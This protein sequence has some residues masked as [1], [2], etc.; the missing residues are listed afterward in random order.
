MDKRVYWIWLSH[1]FGAGSEKPYSIHKRFEGGVEEFHDGKSALWNSLR[2]ISEKEARLLHTFTLNQ[3]EVLLELSEK[4]GH[5]VITPEC[6]KY[7]EALRNIFDPP[8]VLYY[9]G[10]IP[11]VDRTLTIA[12]VGAR[13]ATEKSMNAAMTIAYQ[14]SLM[15]AIVVSGGAVGIDTAAHKGALRGMGKTIAVLPCGLTNGYLVE[16]YS[17]RERIEE[18]GAVISEYP[19][20]TSVH[21]GTFQIRNRIISGLSSGTVVIQAA[22]KS[23]TLITARHAREQNRDVFVFPGDDGDIKYIGSNALIEDGAKPIKD[24]IDIVEEYSSRYELLED[25]L[26]NRVNKKKTVVEK[27]EKKVL[28]H[29]YIL[30]EPNQ[31]HTK[32]PSG[33]SVNAEKLYRIIEQENAGKSKVHISVLEEKSGLSSG[34]LL[35]AITELEIMGLIKSHSGRNYSLS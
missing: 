13:K 20:D 21:K 34:E 28:K 6:E 35:A 25:M 22:Q 14:L 27:Q 26:E 30:A 12:I 33:L 4:I 9:K 23:G 29:E 18:D 5:K 1:A 32:K 19:M 10:E 7:P 3:A 15:N 11:D 17:L 2:F 31:G 16:N 24:A 8:A